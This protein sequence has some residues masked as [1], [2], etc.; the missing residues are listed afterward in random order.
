MVA[1]E[2]RWLNFG[3]NSMHRGYAD[4]TSLFVGD[5]GDL[6]QYGAECLRQCDEL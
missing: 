5:E 6:Q 2:D 4:L 3:W 1:E